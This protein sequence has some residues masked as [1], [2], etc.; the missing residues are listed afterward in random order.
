MNALLSG[1]NV[2]ISANIISS[3]ISDVNKALNQLSVSVGG[4]FFVCLV[5]RSAD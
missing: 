4:M 1:A 2:T 3:V 5:K